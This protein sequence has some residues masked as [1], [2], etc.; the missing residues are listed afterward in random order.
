MSQIRTNSIVPAGGLVGNGGGIIQVV[1][2]VKTN[3]Q[4]FSHNGA[5]DADV[6]ITGLSVTITPQS[7]SSKIWIMGELTGCS[8]AQNSIYPIL[9]R[10]GSKLTGSCGA[11]SGSRRQC[12]SSGSAELGSYMQS[13]PYFYLDSPATTSATTYAI[14][15]SS[16]SGSS[17]EVRIN[18]DQYDTNAAY[19]ARTSSTITVMEVSG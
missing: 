13:I 4:S 8:A 14:Y 11:A 19:S 7:S 1:T 16:S 15:C 18:Y 12:T 2:T 5:S 17:R 3:T 9:Y 10:G 6:A